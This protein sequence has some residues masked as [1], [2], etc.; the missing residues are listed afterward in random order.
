MYSSYINLGERR[1]F[2]RQL[3]ETKDP[4]AR[5]RS[6]ELIAHTVNEYQYL[7]P[8]LRT[9]N[10]LIKLFLAIRTEDY[11]ARGSVNTRRLMG[12]KTYTSHARKSSSELRTESVHRAHSF[13]T[14]KYAD[15]LAAGNIA[16]P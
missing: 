16:Q 14:I 11:Y 2:L 9:P 5:I 4:S 6:K 12:K 3:R 13:N 1:E 8:T 15:K 10:G 7:S